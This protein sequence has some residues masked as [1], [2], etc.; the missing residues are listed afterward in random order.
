MQWRN[1]QG[2]WQDVVGWQSNTIAKPIKWWV[3]A[4]EFGVGQ[5]RWVLLRNNKVVAQSE[6]FSL[7]KKA[8]EML[9]I[10]IK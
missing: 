10:K 8:R 2:Q 7:P 4:K 1:K 3:S 9:T 5:F 6:P